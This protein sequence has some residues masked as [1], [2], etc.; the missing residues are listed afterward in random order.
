MR[1]FTSET[2]TRLGLLFTLAFA[3]CSSDAKGPGK[4]DAGPSGSADSD[5]DSGKTAVPPIPYACP[6]GKVTAGLNSMTV[7]GGTARAFYADFPADPSRPMG[8]LFSFHGYT[9]T[10]EKFRQEAALDPN[11]N[12]ALP[13][14]VVT[15]DDIGVTLP[16]GLDWNITTTNGNPDIAFFESI[17]GCLNAQYPIDPARIYSFGFSAGA[18]FTNLLHST[19]PK[20]LGAVVAESGGWFNDP[21]E[22]Q[23]VKGLT[24]DWEWPSLNPDDGGAVL[25]THGGPTDVTVLGVF[26]L[27]KAA[28]AAFPFL[29]A[30]NRVVIDCPHNLGHALD[31]D[32]TPAVVS[33]FISAHRAGD[34]SPYR[35]GGFSGFPP[36]CALRL[37]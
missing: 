35:T 23:L 21:I 7:D 3:G 27:E 31:P 17:L 34:P 30:E 15:P 11:A 10:A 37:P 36:A 2:A 5:A 16:V 9:D 29:K 22:Q 18:V 25:L 20:L 8:V 19:H 33:K 12:P 6:S 13:V 26:D 4:S 24:V 28:Q 32:V 14:V 1:I